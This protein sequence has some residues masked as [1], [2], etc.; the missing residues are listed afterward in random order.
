MMDDDCVVAASAGVPFADGA[1]LLSPAIAPLPLLPTFEEEEDGIWVGTMPP[2]DPPRP[3]LLPLP[4][5]MFVDSVGH[6][7][8]KLETFVTHFATS[9]QIKCHGSSLDKRG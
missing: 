1:A 4:K 5:Y 8:T 6:V 7:E 9:F 3:L 2:S